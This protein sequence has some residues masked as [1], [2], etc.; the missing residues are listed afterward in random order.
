MPCKI[1]N[2]SDGLLNSG[3]EIIF[4]GSRA[5]G[6]E[7]YHSV[8]TGTEAFWLTYKESA[9]GLRYADFPSGN[10][11]D[12]IKDITVKHHFEE[13]NLYSVGDGFYNNLSREVKGEGWYMFEIN[14]SDHEVFD[15]NF[16]LSPRNS[17]KIYFS[18]EV[19]ANS[20]VHST[21]YTPDN[22]LLSA[23]INNDFAS[24]HSIP[25]RDGT[26][27]AV[28]INP[29][30]IIS[31]I[32]NLKLINRSDEFVGKYFIAVDYLEIVSE[33]APLAY[34][35]KFIGETEL[36]DKDLAIYI[37][38]FSDN[39][40]ILIDKNNSYHIFLADHDSNNSYISK[41][42][43]EAGTTFRLGASPS[44]IISLMINDS[45]Y[46]DSLRYGIYTAMSQAPDYEDIEIKYF[47]D[48]DAATSYLK[49]CPDKSQIALA[50]NSDIS[51]NSALITHLI[52]LGSSLATS[53]SD[54]DMYVMS[55]IKGS[56]ELVEDMNS[57]G[58]AVL[59][60]FMPHSGG[61]SYAIKTGLNTAEQYSFQANDNSTTERAVVSADSK[62]NLMT[63]KTQATAIYIYHPLFKEATQ[64]LVDHRR[65]TLDMNIKMIS[66]DDIF[67]EANYG[68][69]SPHAI[70]SYLRHAIDNWEAPALFYVTFIGD[71]SWDPRHNLVTSVN[72]A[73]IPTF[74]HPVSDFW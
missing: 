37:G 51:G 34:Q 12:L 33:E 59:S 1:I 54:R 42:V 21:K 28:D 58:A 64:K 18:V 74:G 20:I 5:V 19:K 65:S 45:S 48:I 61:R 47:D 49:S 4:L 23:A 17:S 52:S 71:A 69:K 26:N 14:D 36:L 56:S 55:T 39:N 70:K 2:D 7:T 31:G 10:S 27:F 30:N 57:D 6:E 41:A 9:N 66:V 68:N 35:G 43:G 53:L 29:L 22:Q 38:G 11:E 32:N 67:K 3:D 40:I 72:E 25:V 50:A 24:D 60:G 73:L 15:Y 8:Y 44:S 46:I 16:I 62:S 13:D 63:D